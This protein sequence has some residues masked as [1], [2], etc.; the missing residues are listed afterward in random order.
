MA[1]RFF[2][3]PLFYQGNT[4]TV[5]IFELDVSNSIFP[6]QALPFTAKLHIDWNGKQTPLQTALCHTPSVRKAGRQS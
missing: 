6:G 2:V 4:H 5:P 1:A 3:M